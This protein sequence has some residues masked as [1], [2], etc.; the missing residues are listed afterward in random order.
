MNTPQSIVATVPGRARSR[1][2]SDFLNV[3]PDHRP[4]DRRHNQ[5]R[6]GTAFNLLL[7]L[8]VLVAGEEG[9]KAFTFDQLEE[10]AVFDATPLHANDGVNLMPGQEPR[11]RTRHVF[12]EQ[13]LQR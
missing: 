7:L 1:A 3:P 2:S 10:C 11:Q 8:H 13:N 5:H 6:K 4:V 9:F 12:I